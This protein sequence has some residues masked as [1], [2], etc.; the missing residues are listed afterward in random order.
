[1]KSKERL[2]S[3]CRTAPAII[4]TE[5]CRLDETDE[6]EQ[7]LTI[8]CLEDETA[9]LSLQSRI[10]AMREELNIAKN[11]KDWGGN[12]RIF[13]KELIYPCKPCQETQERQHYVKTVL[14]KH[15]MEAGVDSLYFNA[16]LDDCSPQIKEY[17]NKSLF[18]Y[19]P[20]GIG[21]THVIIALLR[22]DI[23]DKKH[24]TFI[25]SLDLLRKIKTSFN[26]T[27]GQTEQQIIDYY[28]TI[29]NLYLD[30]ISAEKA[31]DWALTIL[32]SIIDIRYRKML[33]TVF[34][35]NIPFQELS[36]L[37]GDRIVSRIIGLCGQP[38]KLNGKDRRLPDK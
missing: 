17:Q 35:S 20:T 1:M 4:K 21:K 33:R 8:D 32:Y 13:N 37:L 22:Q 9:F 29:P 15:L 11:K 25:T 2:C 24:A 27:S 31:T 36:V 19:G 7:W 16:C 38:V 5:S 23:E 6:Y 12:F 14:P 26:Q 28:A 34:T 18:L 30:D 10:D 3:I